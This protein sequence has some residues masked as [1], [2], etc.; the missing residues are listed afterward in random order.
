MELEKESSVKGMY[1]WTRVCWALLAIFGGKAIILKMM[2]QPIW[3]KCGSWIPWSWD[4]WSSH[5]S[6]HLVDPYFFTHMLHGV[7]L[8]AM[9]YRL[10]RTISE[11][12]RFLLAVVLEAAWEIL[13]NSPTIIE[14]YRMAT[15]SKDYLGDSIINSAGDLFACAAG[16]LIAQRLRFNRSIVFFLLTELI[17]LITIRDSLLLNVLMLVWPL[18]AVREWQIGTA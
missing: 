6:Q 11:T 12:S 18:E 1:D 9:L 8:C 2:G 10:P 15:I 17:L 3:C 7:I 13:E 16:Y 5:N 14:R 4:I